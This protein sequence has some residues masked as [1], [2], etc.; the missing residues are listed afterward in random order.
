M[1]NA[2]CG[3]ATGRLPQDGDEGLALRRKDAE[4]EKYEK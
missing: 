3:M 2:E 1:R 4:L